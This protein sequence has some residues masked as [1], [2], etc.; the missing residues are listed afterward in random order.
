[1]TAIAY[2]LHDQSVI[3]LFQMIEPQ[4]EKFRNTK[5]VEMEL[6]FGKIHNKKFEPSI[7][8]ASYERIIKGLEKYKEW[9][10]IIKT[11]TSVYYK[12]DKRIIV[13]DITG[14]QTIMIKKNIRHINHDLDNSPFDVRFSISTENTVEEEEGKDDDVM[15]HVRIK[16][17]KSFIR[18][19]LSID[20]TKVSGEPTDIDDEEESKYEIEFEIVDPTL[21]TDSPTL[22]NIIYKIRDVLKLLD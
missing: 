16:S 1:M 9:E 11:D 4:F 21:I 13:D 14:D 22:F 10:K 19:N 2:K 18:E 15:D 12:K 8:S 3:D 5:N 7:P 17:R 6:R 20:I